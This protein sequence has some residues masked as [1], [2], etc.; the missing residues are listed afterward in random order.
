[1]GKEDALDNLLRYEPCVSM[2]K[3]DEGLR[4][5]IDEYDMLIKEENAIMLVS[6]LARR[7][8]HRTIFLGAL[9]CALK[10]TGNYPTEEDLKK[11]IA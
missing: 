3:T 5:K 1:M 7:L 10:M 6:H 4:V 2:T 8:E 9:V 11:I